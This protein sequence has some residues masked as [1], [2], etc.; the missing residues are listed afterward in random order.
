[1]FSPLMYTTNDDEDGDSVDDSVDAD[2]DE[3]IN[4]DGGNGLKF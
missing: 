2:D 3:Y 4:D 1:M